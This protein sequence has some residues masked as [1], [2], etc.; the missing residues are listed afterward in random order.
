MSQPVHFDKKIVLFTLAAIALDIII[1]TCIRAKNEI[2]KNIP[3]SEAGTSIL[4][5]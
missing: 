5:Q 3:T 2:G 1:E 4:D